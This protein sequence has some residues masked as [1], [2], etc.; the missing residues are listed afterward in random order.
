MEVALETP[1]LLLRRF[2]GSDLDACAEMLADPEVMKFLGTGVTFNRSEAW[3]SIASILGHWQLLGYGMWALELKRTGAFIGRA[4]FLD[5][6]DW[7]GFELGWV[8][9]RAHWGQGC[10]SEAARAALDYAFTVLRRERVIS[11]IREGNDRSVRVAE[12]LG[13]R[14][15]GEVELLGSKARVY[16]VRRDSL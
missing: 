2:R 14:Y 11:L 16:E 13:E 5:P 3:R 9:G 8:L 12:K 15:A 1:R 6:P 10:A 7:P 4:G